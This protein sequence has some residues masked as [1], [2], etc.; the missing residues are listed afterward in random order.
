MLHLAQVKKNEF[1]GRVE[2][3]LLARQQA[4]HTW[5]V[6]APED[7]FPVIK[8]TDD[9]IGRLYLKEG[10][11][12]LVEIAETHQ[13]LS[14]REAKDWVLDLIRQYLVGGLTP[15]FLQRETERA[16]E[17]RQELTLQSQE[18][19]RRTMEMEARQEQIQAL[20]AELERKTE[21]IERQK[22]DIKKMA[23]Q[24]KLQQQ[25]IQEQEDS[26][27]EHQT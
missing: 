24:L 25:Q 27:G 18:L 11:L 10:L 26:K 2:L 19:A 5:A 4:E 20:E 13:V 9:P 17:W 8:G 22:Q 3:R 14:I 6:I 23:E 16:E 21:D 1:S 15:D 12:V 7:V